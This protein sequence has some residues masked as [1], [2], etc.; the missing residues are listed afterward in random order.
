MEKRGILALLFKLAKVDQIYTFAEFMYMMEIGRK[1]GFKDEEI[2]KIQLESETI[3]MQIP[4]LEQERMTIFYY[5]LFL[6]KADQ[7]ATEEEIN[8]VRRIGFRLGFD[9]ILTEE[10]IEQIIEHLS[11][12]VDPEIMIGIIKKHMN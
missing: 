3:K 9:E 8:F 7:K 11:D 5:A 4:S 2:R 12:D 1:M 10:L 6:M